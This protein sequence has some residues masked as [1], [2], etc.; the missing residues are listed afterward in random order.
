MAFHASAPRVAFAVSLGAFVASSAHAAD[1]LTFGR[2]SQRNGYNPNETVLNVQTAPGLHQLW[3]SAL[4]GPVFAQP[5]LA[6]GVLVDD[7]TGTGNRVPLD[8]V[9]AVDLGGG[10]SALD[11]RNGAFVWQDQLPAIPTTCTDFPGL[12]VGIAGTPT[13]DKPNNRL[14]VVA[15][16][17]TLWALDLGTGYPLPGYPLQVLDPYNQ[18]GHTVVYSSPTYSNGALYVATG[19]QCDIAPY[20]GQIIKVAV[21]THATDLPSIAARWYPEGPPAISAP[22]GG[23]IWGPGGVSV[24]DDGSSLYAATGN[25]LTQPD[26]AGYADQ[27]VKLDPNLQLMANFVPQ[28]Q[29]EDVDFGATPLLYQPP[30]CPPLM[31]TMNKSGVLFVSKR[32]TASLKAGPLQRIEI[33]QTADTGGFIGI[34]VYAPGA[35][36]L[37]LGNPQSD[38]TG[39]YPHGLLAFKVQPDCTLALAWQRT[40]GFNNTDVPENPIIPAVSANGVVYYATGIGS[41]VYA[42]DYRGN[43]LWDSG[44]QIHGGVF[45]APTVVNGML[46]VA[47]GN[48]NITAFGP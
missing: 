8:I 25:A 23:G 22:E 18:N 28:L 37:Y 20:R 41:L 15:G 38:V 14:W 33:T 10:V 32:D 40:I 26:N 12:Q 5:T 1:W 31:A 24:E 48:G 39:K 43:H 11:A 9:Y 27:I 47:D 7:G 42:Y 19:S 45:A 44:L 35:N 2:T 36:Q 3:S 17:G 16:D 4:T 34:P 13:I 21:G 30:G 6:S 29:G 46:L